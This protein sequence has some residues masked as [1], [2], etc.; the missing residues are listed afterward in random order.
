MLEVERAREAGRA[1]HA[2]A[3]LVR[4]KVDA[5]KALNL[6]DEF[7]DNPLVKATFFTEQR[8]RARRS[9]L[10]DQL[11]DA[12]R[13]VVAAYRSLLDE[14][15]VW[16]RLAQQDFLAEDITLRDRVLLLEAVELD[17]MPA[18]A[19]L[20]YGQ[21]PPPPEEW[22]E[23]IQQPLRLLTT[24]GAPGKAGA[25]AAEAEHNLRQLVGRL[26]ALIEVV[27]RREELDPKQ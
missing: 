14:R 11:A 27:D 3:A 22:V 5:D 23:R 4:A 9:D 20:G 18:L 26:E 21:G 2:T 17:L 10:L 24:G 25:L 16:A 13:G 19:S 6:D 7:E 12:S 15:H 8:R 1:D